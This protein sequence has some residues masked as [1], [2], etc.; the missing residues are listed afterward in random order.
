MILSKHSS[1][2]TGLCFSSDGSRLASC[3]GRKCL[4]DGHLD[5]DAAPGEIIVWD[6]ATWDDCV[7]IQTMP[8]REFNGVA[9]TEDG[10]GLYASGNV[11]LADL[12]LPVKGAL[13]YWSG[14]QAAQPQFVVN[15]APAAR[16]L[17][18]TVLSYP[19]PNYQSVYLPRYYHSLAIHPRKP[20][21]AAI[22]N[23][24][25][26]MIWD[27]TTKQV[28]NTKQLPAPSQGCVWHFPGGYL[29]LAAPMAHPFSTDGSVMQLELEGVGSQLTLL[30]MSDLS[31]IPDSK[32]QR[33]EDGSLQIALRDR[34]VVLDPARPTGTLQDWA[35]TWP[36]SSRSH[37][38]D[39]QYVAE[40]QNKDA[41]G[42][43]S[44]V[45]R[46]TSTVGD[47]ILAS[48][49]LDDEYDKLLQ[50]GFSSDGRTAYALLFKSKDKN[51]PSALCVRRIDIVSRRELTPVRDILNFCALP[52]DLSFC[53]T[54]PDQKSVFRVDLATGK[55]SDNPVAVAEMIGAAAI[56]PDCEH[57]A[58]TGRNLDIKIYGISRNGMRQ[59]RLCRR[60]EQR[61]IGKRV[62]R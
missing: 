60:I 40:I 1:G 17:A 6:T 21:V 27:A 45:F 61:Q 19:L 14:E 48:A 47:K 39:G 44:N 9:F 11:A 42:G 31:E 43:N 24:N 18:G 34:T 52:P 25:K 12:E 35:P 32:T 54:S 26:L 5:S 3:S 36:G 15:Q 10:R 57:F 33:G 20:V 50:I 58:A 30:D 23:N 49:S 4:I 46:V 29:R 22:T 51:Y 7:Q 13:F 37:S 38:G 55:R 59:S 56:F 8:P 41:A 2:V 53:L 16:D 62:A 28:V